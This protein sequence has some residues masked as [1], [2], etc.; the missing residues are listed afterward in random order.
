MPDPEPRGTA[1]CASTAQAIRPVRKSEYNLVAG[2]TWLFAGADM[3]GAPVDVLIIDEAGQLALADALAA[4]TSAQERH[5]AGRSAP[6]S[7]SR[8]GRSTPAV[9]ELSVLEH[10]LGDDVTLPPHRGVFLHETRRCTPTCAGSSRKEIYEG[11][12]GEP[13]GLRRSSDG[14]RDWTAVARGRA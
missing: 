6:A 4:S 12:A 14:V 2:T 13:S 8:P 3:R 9:G 1:R 10:V 7:P 5:P 11:Q